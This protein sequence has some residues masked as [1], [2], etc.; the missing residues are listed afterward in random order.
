MKFWFVALLVFG[1]VS[2]NGA[3]TPN[4]ECQKTASGFMCNDGL[5]CATA[6]S[7]ITC[8]NGVSCHGGGA[9]G[10]DCSNGVFCTGFNINDYCSNG[11][12]CS[13]YSQE[14]HC[15]KSPFAKGN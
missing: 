12:I 4:F 10:W 3:V 13:T 9:S 6:A 11:A 5:E 2:A 14:I 15:T 8:S 7:Q 1:F